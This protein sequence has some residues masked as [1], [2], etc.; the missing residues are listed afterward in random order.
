[1]R[2]ERDT[3]AAWHG[4][5][6][7]GVYATTPLPTQDEKPLLLLAVLHGRP[8]PRAVAAILAEESELALCRPQIRSISESLQFDKRHEMVSAQID[9]LRTF[10][11]PLSLACG[12]E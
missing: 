1:L 3:L 4:K 8:S 6:I 10:G 9:R 5:R 11:L 2:G 12:W 7:A